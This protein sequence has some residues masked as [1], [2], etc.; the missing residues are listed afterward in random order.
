MSSQGFYLS[1]AVVSGLRGPLDDITPG[2]LR[3]LV[4]TAEA[5]SSKCRQ[6]GAS[7]RLSNELPVLTVGQEVGAETPLSRGSTGIR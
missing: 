4:G 5:S 3:V 6:R 1:K 2:T 7:P